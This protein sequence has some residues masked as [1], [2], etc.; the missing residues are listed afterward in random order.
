MCCRAVGFS[1]RVVAAS[2]A[3]FFLEIAAVDLVEV[4]G[5]CDD[6]DFEDVA[7]DDDD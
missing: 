5:R 6:S 1:D 7:G 4:K 3:E 2:V